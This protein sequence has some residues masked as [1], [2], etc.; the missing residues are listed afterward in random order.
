MANISGKQLSKEMISIKPGI[1][2]ILCTRFGDE[3]DEQRA[4]A[5]GIKGFLKKPVAMRDMAEMVRKVLEEASP[6]VSE[7][8]STPSGVS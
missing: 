8:V 7:H 5:M 4:M 2:I 3:Y 1:P 6:R